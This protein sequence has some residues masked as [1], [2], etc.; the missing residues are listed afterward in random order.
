[1][2]NKIDFQYLI[3][4]LL[5]FFL[6]SCGKR[7]P[8]SHPL[9]LKTDQKDSLEK[10]D[11]RDKG[12]SANSSNKT[13]MMNDWQ[14]M[15]L[16]G[17]VRSLTEIQYR[18]VKISGQSQKKYKGKQTL[19]FNENGRLS[20]K[21][22][23]DDDSRNSQVYDRK[24]YIYNGEERLIEIGGYGADSTLRMNCLFKYDNNGK[25]IEEDI[26][27]PDKHLDARY[28]FL[29]D[30]NGKK[31]EMNRFNMKTG[32]NHDL[33]ERY[34]YDL[35]GNL[36]EKKT[37]HASGNF[38]SRYKY[39]YDS[40]DRIV[41]KNGF[42]FY[43]DGHNYEY[44]INYRYDSQ[45]NLISETEKSKGIS[46]TTKTLISLDRQNNWIERT[47]TDTDKTVFITERKIEYFD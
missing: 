44:K 3:G 39:T 16:K 40:T 26:S 37:E 33:K 17:K 36:T 25:V 6:G 12:K 41:E 13:V 42:D 46:G 15:N 11:N 30:K 24:L 28:T 23:F 29:Y 43:S 7:T 14:E 19:E 18:I 1:M 45:G 2:M 9:V 31:I 38:G 20:Q 10:H 47:T 8:D 34:A 22:D 5:V 32:G 35:L 4:V 27:G 21:I